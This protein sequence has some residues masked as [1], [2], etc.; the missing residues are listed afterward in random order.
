MKHYILTK[1]AASELASAVVHQDGEL[2][3]EKHQDTNFYKAII[4][5][6]F[7]APVN[8]AILEVEATNEKT[9]SVNR[10][11]DEEKFVDLHF[12]FKLSDEV[13][14]RFISEKVAPAIHSSIE[15]IL[16]EKRQDWDGLE[17]E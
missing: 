11:N 2:Y 8:N 12:R 15:K 10:F 4:N 13:D 16:K 17:D 9:V 7:I 6:N 1:D 14:A 3:L 5:D